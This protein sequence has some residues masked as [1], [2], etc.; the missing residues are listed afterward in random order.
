LAAVFNDFNLSIKLDSRAFT[1]FGSGLSFPSNPIGKGTNAPF[2]IKVG[3]NGFFVVV[4]FDSCSLEDFSS[5][6]KILE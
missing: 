2:S 5:G 4:V 1:F 6:S 3:S